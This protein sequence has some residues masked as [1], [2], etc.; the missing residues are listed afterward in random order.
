MFSMS[1]K[2]AYKTNY[3]G[4]DKINNDVLDFVF[5][6]GPD[7]KVSSIAGKLA[8]L[9]VDIQAKTYEKIIE[10]CERK[11]IKYA[12]LGDGVRGVDLNDIPPEANSLVIYGHGSVISNRHKISL[13]NTGQAVDTLD[14]I[15]NAK[16]KII[17]CAPAF[18]KVQICLESHSQKI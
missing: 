6:I 4:I 14:I 2:K 8:S 13:T 9:A 15:E 12:I 11:G 3:S 10:H 18:A 5:L 16:I 17:M 7:K 1:K